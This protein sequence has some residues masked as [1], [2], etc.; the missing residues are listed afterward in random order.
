MPRLVESAFAGEVTA[1]ATTLS[2]FNAVKRIGDV[3]A[4]LITLPLSG[5]AMILIGLV[6]RVLDGPE[7]LF[8][9][10]REGLRGKSF[11]ALKFRTMS[12]ARDGSGEL[13]PDRQR[14]TRVGGILRRSSLDELP[15]LLNVL[16]GDMALVGPRPLY[17]RYSSCYTTRERQRKLV[18]PGITGLAQT[19]GRN[20]VGWTQRLE[21]DV[22]YVEHHS[23][24]L[25]LV[26]L[27]GTVRKAVMGEGIDIIAGDSG[28]PLDVERSYPRVET[29]ALRRLYRGD[30]ETRVL[31][32]SDQRTRRYMTLKGEVTLRS[33][34]EWYD[35]V[36]IDERRKD[37]VA[38]VPR[39]G[40]VLAMAG[41]TGLEGG[42]AEYYIFVD[43]DGTGRGIGTVT[44]DLV[45]EWARRS[46]FAERVWLAVAA[47]NTRALK[48]YERCGFRA[49]SDEGSE[50]LVMTHDM[51]RLR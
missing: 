7:P 29:T 16:K 31:W 50:R 9:Q 14:L 46:H 23:F 41:L 39:T 21:L 28:D 4:V 1:E 44:T 12:Q 27:V 51:G 42:S 17:T 8:R 32:L 13:L 37:F 38:Y 49:T 10:E 35:R 6:I 15:Q 34:A 26:I 24:L 33:T 40:Q 5:F 43:P 47:S 30:L 20:G 25:D 45:V 22:Q 48:T 19:S 2:R 3:I 18:R 36:R 11:Q